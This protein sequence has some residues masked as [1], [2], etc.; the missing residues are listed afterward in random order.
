MWNRN[1]W[2]YG[3]WW[4][5]AMTSWKGSRWLKLSVWWDELSRKHPHRVCICD[6]LLCCQTEQDSFILKGYMKSLNDP[7][8]LKVSCVS[9]SPEWPRPLLLLLKLLQMW[10]VLMGILVFG[11]GQRLKLGL[12]V[13]GRNAHS[14][15]L[16]HVVV[17]SEFL[18]T[19][20]STL[21]DTVITFTLLLRSEVIYKVSLDL[22][23]CFLRS[24]PH[25]CVYTNCKLEKF[26]GLVLI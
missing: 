26:L 20:V 16:Q 18:L 24:N 8:M 9:L 4:G 1:S 14:G 25:R 3:R 5:N 15:L 23:R 6:R 13:G 11:S 21:G 12:W 7:V 17:L 2:N 10:C 19:P 22:G